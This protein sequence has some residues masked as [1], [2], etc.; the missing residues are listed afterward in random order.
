[1][2]DLRQIRDDPAAFDAGLRR[3]GLPPQS[4]EILALDAKRR[5]AQ[6]RLQEHQQRRNEVSRQVGAAK[7]KGQD[8]GPLMAEVARL[9]DAMEAATAEEQGAATELEQILAGI[10]NL[11]AADVPHG[12]DAE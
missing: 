11:P 6:T 4:A 1:M 2:H 7:S 12:A 3:R 10:P 8:A 5:A 9:K